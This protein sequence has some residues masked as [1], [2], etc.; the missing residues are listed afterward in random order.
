[1]VIII[2]VAAVLG[3][4]GGLVVERVKKA[5]KEAPI[6]APTK[7]TILADPVGALADDTSGGRAVLCG[8]RHTSDHDYIAVVL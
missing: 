6:S 2:V 3:G 4:I 5:R 8:R 7:P 1:M